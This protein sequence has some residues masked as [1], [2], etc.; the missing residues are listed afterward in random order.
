[1]LPG[2]VPWPEAFA[3]RYRERGY[4]RGI[5]LFEM[6]RQSA[7]RT[8]GKT[9][10]IDGERRLSYAQL[11]SESED[12]AAGLHALGLRPLE[13]VIFQFSNGLELMV[14][15][16]ALLRVGVIPVMALPAHRR[17]EIG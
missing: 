17:S 4:W 10:L 12:L 15:L 16:F 8:P 11:V 2:C 3:R 13:R 9:A 6:L 7:A 5:S 1:M 14:A